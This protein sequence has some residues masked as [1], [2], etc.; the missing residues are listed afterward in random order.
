MH[1][2]RPVC[3]TTLVQNDECSR[4][5]PCAIV[6]AVPLTA[7]AKKFLELR[8]CGLFKNF[9]VV[10]DLGP[11]RFM[12]GRCSATCRCERIW[13][14]TTLVGALKITNKLEH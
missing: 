14:G 11:A 12:L 4:L 8:V 2:C 5:E 13:D 10:L 3:G 9:D 1:R 7:F 6:I